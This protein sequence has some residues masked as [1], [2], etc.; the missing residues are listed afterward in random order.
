MANVVR[1]ENSGAESRCAS[2]RYNGKLFAGLLAA[3][4]SADSL[5][6]N[7]IINGVM[8]KTDLA[9]RCTDGVSTSMFEFQDSAGPFYASRDLTI[10]G[11]Y[12]NWR[13]AKLEL[14]AGRTI[15]LTGHMYG[16]TANFNCKGGVYDFQNK[17]GFNT[18]GWNEAVNKVGMTLD[19]AVFTNM[20]SVVLQNNSQAG[21]TWTM[22]NGA[23]IHASGAFTM[24]A[25]NAYARNLTMDMSS[26]SK[27]FCSSF[28]TDGGRDAASTLAHFLKLTGNGTKLETLGTSANKIGN[29][30]PFA[31]VNVSDHAELKLG[32]TTYIGMEALSYS[33][34]LR[35]FGSAT[36]TLGPLYLGCNGGGSNVV[37]VAGES[38][39]TTE[40]L[41]LNG[42]ASSVK[43]NSLIVS[44]ATV[45]AKTLCSPVSKGKDTTLRVSGDHPK[46]RVNS[47]KLAYETAFEMNN[48]VKM[49]FD[50]PRTGYVDDQ[51]PIVVTGTFDDGGTVSE[52]PM[53]TF[54]T[55]PKTLTIKLNGV[56]EF[57]TW[58]EKN[59]EISK[60]KIVLMHVAGGI[61]G[62][63]AAITAANQGLPE[64]CFLY[65]TAGANVGLTG[66]TALVLEVG[67]HRGLVITIQ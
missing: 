48:G 64:K 5:G 39:L 57:Q 6:A 22:K 14:D 51:I 7:V 1:R 34:A 54:V 37:E 12:D 19:G 9:G 35:L 3:L 46:I 58:L 21:G 61:G 63:D 43:G 47:G 16:N 44:N 13:S 23:R 60:K 65:T 67:A 50:I 20:S 2:L 25:G 31:E 41:Y 30:A 38:V 27:F 66:G 17:Y 24:V 32:G 62:Y 55:D 8:S 26:G 49:V 59:T 36:A 11:M 53:G 56:D 33:N 52:R 15:T 18:G 45:N 10:A 40:D 29:G 4:L 28:Q 42:G